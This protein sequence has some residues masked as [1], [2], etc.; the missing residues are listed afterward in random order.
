MRQRL[1]LRPERIQ[2]TALARCVSLTLCS[3]GDKAKQ[4]GDYEADW[5]R[6]EMQNRGVY[7]HGA[8][9]AI[10]EAGQEYGKCVAAMIRS[11][12]LFIEADNSRVERCSV[13]EWWDDFLQT[14]EMIKHLEKVKAVQKADRIYFWLERQISRNLAMAREMFGQDFIDYLCD[15]GKK[16]LKENQKAL[17]DDY[18]RKERKTA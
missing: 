17:V 5:V 11:T 13:A 14:V 7:A 3:Q 6:V 9:N 8:M 15:H 10:V 16:N 2:G 1:L 12:L 4:Q 18:I